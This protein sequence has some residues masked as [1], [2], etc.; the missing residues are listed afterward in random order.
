M[1][2]QNWVAAG[3][4]RIIRTALAGLRETN[5]SLAVAGSSDHSYPKGA[6]TSSFQNLRVCA[7]S[8]IQSCSTLRNPVNC[9]PPGSSFHGIIQARQ[10]SGKPS[11]AKP[12][13]SGQGSCFWSSSHPVWR[14]RGHLPT[15]TLLSL[16]C[17]LLSPSTGQVNREPKGRKG[18][19]NSVHVG[20]CSNSFSQSNLQAIP[21][22]FVR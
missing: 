6:T 2:C 5:E 12:W 10:L 1:A 16:S 17:Y 15:C 13:A 18:S 20:F 8:V 22:S 9:S 7:L 21:T 14:S 3:R 19:V 4:L 11:L